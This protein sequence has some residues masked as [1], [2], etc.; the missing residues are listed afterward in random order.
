MSAVFL[1]LNNLL[2]LTTGVNLPTVNTKQKN[3]EFLFYF[4]CILKATEEKG[5][6]RICNPVSTDPRIR[7]KTSRIWNTDF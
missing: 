5:R 1:L 6:I 2:S 3:L 4:F 7:I